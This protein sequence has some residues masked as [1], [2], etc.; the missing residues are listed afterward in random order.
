LQTGNLTQAQ[1]DLSTLMQ[2]FPATQS[3]GNSSVLS[4]A[5]GALSQDLQ[6]GNLSAA[7]QDYSTLQQGIQ[8]G[9]GQVHHHR[10]GHRGGGGEQQSQIAQALNSLGQ[11]LQSG[12]LQSAQAAF[13]TLQQDLQQSSSLFGGSTSSTSSSSSF[14]QSASGTLN[15]TA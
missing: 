3:A 4:Q 12:N 14:A 11:A 15:V 10:H 13:A 9:A 6:N 7:Q 5:F 1:Q 8:Q 2:N